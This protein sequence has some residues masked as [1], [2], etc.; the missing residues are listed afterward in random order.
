MGG[1]SKLSQTPMQLL[2][3]IPRSELEARWARVRRYMECDALIVLQNVGIFYLTGTTQTGVLWF[4]SEGEPVLAVRKSYER[5]TAESPLK[6]IVPFRSY[7]DLPSLLP[8]PGKTLGFELDVVPVSTYE[9]VA[10]HFKTST[11]VD[12]S[13]VLRKARGVKTP[14]EIDRIRQAAQQLDRAFLDIPGQLR[15][16][17]AEID[18]GARIEFVM[19][20]AGHQ[21]LTRVRRF[22]MEM[23]YGAVSFGDTAAYPH[24]FD[25]PVGVRGL[26][27]AVPAMGGWK[28]LRRGEPVIVDIVG[29]CAGYIADGTRVYSLGSLPQEL[30][31]AHAYALDL[32]AWIEEQ[33]RP[34]AIPGEIY[35]RILER[36]A[37]SPYGSQFMGAGDN[38]VKFVAHSVGLELDELPVIAPKY[39]APFEVNTVM[40]VEPK[41]FF[42]GIGGVGT[43]NTYVI[44]EGPPER[45]T[46]CAQEI[47]VVPL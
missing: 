46:T 21:G 29:G 40:A 2:D 11:L 47:Y 42:P 7:S 27:T 15:E 44:R 5:A 43:E 31:N 38:Q 18:L 33:L 37:Q 16:G 19:R 8:N 20:S 13:L 36:V 1:N 4:P 39:D 23:H 6:N 35:T 17:M 45:L 3:Y 24:S 22:N 9:Q 41:I 32:N 25:G 34:G 30:R 14:Y 28:Q 12:A 26:Y 10:K